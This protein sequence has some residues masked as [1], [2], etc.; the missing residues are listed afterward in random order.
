MEPILLVGLGKKQNQYNL[1]NCNLGVIIDY[2]E[3]KKQL[4]LIK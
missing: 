1:N 2:I 4:N 3:Q